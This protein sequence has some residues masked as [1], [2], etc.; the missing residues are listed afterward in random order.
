MHC[1]GCTKQLFN[2]FSIFSFMCFSFFID[3]HML[4]FAMDMLL[5]ENNLK[6]LYSYVY[7]QQHGQVCSF[8]FRRR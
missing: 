7:N 8:F 5:R 6:R 3:F 4:F 1:R 2:I